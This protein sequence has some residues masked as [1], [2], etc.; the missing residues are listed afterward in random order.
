MAR[1]ANYAILFFAIAMFAL[2]TSTVLLGSAFALTATYD[3]SHEH[4]TDLTNPGTVCGDH[5]C[6]PGEMPQGPSV[7]TPVKEIQ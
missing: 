5:V 3:Y 6:A 2:T 7:V 4:T 1:V